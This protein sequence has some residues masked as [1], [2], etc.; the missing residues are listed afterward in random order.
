VSLDNN[1]DWE[2]AYYLGAEHEPF[3]FGGNNT[4]PESLANMGRCQNVDTARLDNRATLLHSFDALRRN[5]DATPAV[6]A[7]DKIQS[8]ALEIVTSGAVR[9]AFEVELEAQSVR[10]RYGE[11]PFTVRSQDCLKNY[12]QQRHPGR[13]LLQ[14]RR[15]IEAGVS[16]VTYCCHNWD[17]HRYNFETLRA[18]L[19]HLDQAL[20]ALVLDLEERGLLN[21]VAVVMGGEFGRTPRIGDIQPDGRSHWPEAGFLWVAGGG[22]KTGQVIGQTDRRGERVI[23]DPIRMQQVLATMYRVLGIDPAATFRDFNGRP[24]YVLEDRRPVAGLV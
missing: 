15:L 12:H 8:R 13:A 24:Q 11:K 23:G 1:A 21:D 4:A 18:V 7:L 6:S 19:P 3:R 17:T 9:E 10:D 16:V 14:A 2:R 22:L 20:T 5:L